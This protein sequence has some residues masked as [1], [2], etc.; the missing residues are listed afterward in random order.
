[1]QYD[2]FVPDFKRNLLLPSFG[3]RN[4][5]QV[6]IEACSS[7]TSQETKHTTW[8]KKL[9]RPSSELHL[10]KVKSSGMLCCVHLKIVTGILKECWGKHPQLYPEDEGTMIL[11]NMATIH[12][13][14]WC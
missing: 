2:V 5:V 7:T 10:P 4:L 12:Q 9:K 1:M 8:R 11:R 14:T 13:S 3:G 6:D